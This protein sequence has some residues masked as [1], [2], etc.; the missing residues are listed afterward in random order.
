[1]ATQQLL[2]RNAVPLD[3]ARHRDLCIRGAAGHRFAD[4][5]NSVPLTAIE[6][7]YAAS[8]YP[9]VF[10]GNAQAVFPAVALGLRPGQ[11]LM[12]G[13]DGRWTAGYVPA[14]VRRYPF[15]LGQEAGGTRLTVLI[16]EAYE[17][18]NRDGA[19]ERLFDADGNQTKFLRDA[20]AFLQDYQARFLRTQAFCTRLIEEKLLRPMQIQFKAGEEARTLSGFMTI[21]RERLKALAPDVLADMVAKDELECCYLHLA[22]LRNFQTLAE[23]LQAQS[24]V[25]KA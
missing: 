19:G 3:A 10:A 21:D 5:I 13:A 23:R 24:A 17:G 15:V 9:I 18:C 25:A 11:N 7:A 16:D 12:L 20:V 2:Y 4:G 6:F 22:S 14:F 8:E 1:M